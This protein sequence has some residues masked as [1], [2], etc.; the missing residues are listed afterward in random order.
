MF[1][2]L[3]IPCILCD[4]QV[5]R[6][7]ALSVRDRKGFA[8]CRFCVERWQATGAICSHCR[9][10]LRGAQELGI[11]LEGDRSFGHADCGALRLMAA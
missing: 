1:G 4:Q 9:T 3:K 10:P 7:D 6:R 11:L 8:V 5:A 2:F